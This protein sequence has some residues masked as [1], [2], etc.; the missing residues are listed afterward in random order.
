MKPVSE[1]SYFR[2]LVIMM[3]LILSGVSRTGAGLSAQNGLGFTSAGILGV[4]DSV[5]SSSNFIQVQAHL[6]N[7]DS[8]PFTANDTLLFVGYIDTIGTNQFTIPI[9]FPPVTNFNLLPG[10]SVN[11]LIP[12]IFLDNQMGGQYRIGNN[13]IVVWPISYSPNFSMAHDSITANV[14]VMD[15]NSVEDLNENAAVRFYPVPANGPLYVT[16]GTRS[17]S[18]KQVTVTDASG[19]IISVSYNP[20]SGIKTDDW[21]PGIYILEITFDNGQKSNYKIIK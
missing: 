4:P 19:K 5:F 17:V 18:V 16:T 13:V 14:F 10:D 2:L 9:S 11:L 15:P 7:Y 21:A 1:R 6:R 20:T 8:I 12:F 3:M